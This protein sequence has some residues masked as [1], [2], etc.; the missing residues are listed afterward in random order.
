MQRRPTFFNIAR[1]QLPVGAVTSILHRVTGTL[2]ALAIPVTAY[3]LDL[4]LR[5][6]DS[7]VRVVGFLDN[8]LVRVAIIILVWALTHHFLAGIR[9]L[10][11]GIDIGSELSVARRSAWFVNLCA[12]LVALLAVSV[13]L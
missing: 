10:L 11:S 5:S 6:P 9:H 4:S 12:A 7:Y 1:I 8:M 2:M 3:V 13:L